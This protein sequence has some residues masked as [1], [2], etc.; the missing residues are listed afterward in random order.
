MMQFRIATASRLTL[1]ASRAAERATEVISR[2]RSRQWTRGLVGI[3]AL[4]LALAAAGC[5]DDAVGRARTTDGKQPAGLTPKQ[6]SIVL[7]K[8]GDHTIT[9]GEFAAT[10]ERMDQMDRL[11]YRTPE[12]RRELLQQMITVELLAQEA[13]RRGLQDKPSVKEGM[14]QILRDAVLRDAHKNARSPVEFTEQEVRTYYQEH[15]DRYRIPERRRVGDIVVDDEKKARKLI[16]KAQDLDA[17]QWGELVV[18]NSMSY[19]GKK[20]TG[21]VESAGDLGIVGPPGNKRGQ[22]PRVPEQVRQAVFQIAG[23]GKVLDHPVKDSQG[24]WHVVR[25]LSKTA[26]HMRSFAE[27]ERTIRIKLS[28]QDIAQREEQLRSSLMKKFPPQV[29]EQALKKVE[30]PKPVLRPAAPIDEDEEE[31]EGEH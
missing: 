15:A 11:R 3:A 8:V 22:N 14:R 21:P 27:A 7:A 18:K 29:D 2:G 6:A 17:K 19:K 1:H 31:E 4:A 24:R 28:Q 9:L 16:E 25:L 20:W 5:R 12:R 13:R 10:L 26:A 23:V 30:V